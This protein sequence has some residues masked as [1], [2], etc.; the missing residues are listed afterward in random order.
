VRPFLGNISGVFKDEHGVTIGSFKG[1]TDV[2][3]PISARKKLNRL[4]PGHGRPVM[5]T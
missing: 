3:G 5:T 1:I 2:I 4:D